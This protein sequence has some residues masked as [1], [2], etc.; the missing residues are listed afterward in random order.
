ML[1]VL[2]LGVLAYA[3]ESVKSKS[4][5][6][7][8][9]NPMAELKPGPGVEQVRAKCTACH[10]TDYIVRQPG[11]SRE[12][13]QAEIKKMIEAFGAPIS[14]QDAEVIVEYLASTYA[15]QSNPP[16]AEPARSPVTRRTPEK[17]H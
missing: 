3:R 8:Q 16:R 14:A 17:L 13:W 1:F 12:K 4:I 2:V 7:P 15:P 9:D 11:G 5:E 10:S 6:L